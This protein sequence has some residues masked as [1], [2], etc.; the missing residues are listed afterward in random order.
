MIIEE[1]DFRLEQHDCYDRFDLEL[2]HVVNAKDPEKRREE[3]K[4]AGYAMTLDTCLN[5][6]L[7]Y[8][9]DKKIEVGTLADYI[10][11][12]REERKLLS[13]LLGLK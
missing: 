3:F 4:E 6:I 13:E 9:I 11:L 7:N 5:K 12:Y 2:L 10:K 1:K 8:R